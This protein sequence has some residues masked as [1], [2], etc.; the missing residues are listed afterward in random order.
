MYMIHIKISTKLEQWTPKRKKIIWY[1]LR[2]EIFKMK[3]LN[4]LQFNKS[5]YNN[6]TKF[7]CV[8]LFGVDTRKMGS[9]NSNKEQKEIDKYRDKYT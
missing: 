5:F 6:N 8:W 2:S 4:H 1:I 9:L 7:Y 3:A